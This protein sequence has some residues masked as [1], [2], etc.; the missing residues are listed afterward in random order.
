MDPIA[1]HIGSFPIRWYG[2]FVAAGFLAGYQLV[3][4]RAGRI[5]EI[6]KEEAANLTFLGMV[7][8]ILGARIFHVIM[9]W[10]NYRDSLLEI[11][12]IDHGGL[13]FYGGFFGAVLVLV[14]RCRMKKLSYGAV[15]E[16]LVPAL[17]LGHALGRVGCF[18]N[19]CCFGRPWDGWPAVH[20]PT[21]SSVAYVQIQKGLISRTVVSPLPVFSIQLLA[22]ALN[23]GILAAL[24]L[25]EKKYSLR[26]RALPLYLIFYGM[27][28]FAVEFGRGDYL[29]MIGPFTPAQVICMVLVPA[30]VLWM[31]FLRSTEKSAT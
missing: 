10:E 22:A 21:H 19:G 8:G 9:F 27:G 20:Y 17:P 5:T 11:F 30:G 15:A 3:L 13:V 23:L 6:G 1:F 4:F 18:L 26:N 7:G 14:L 29:D 28:R 31:F 25:I 2:I 24:L 16:V 12:R